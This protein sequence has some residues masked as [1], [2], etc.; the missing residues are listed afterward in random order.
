LWLKVHAPERSETDAAAEQAFATGHDVGAIARTLHTDGVMVPM[1]RGLSA[2]VRAT[3]KLIAES[4]PGPIFEATF[5]HDGVLVQVDVLSRKGRKG[6]HVAEVKSSTSMDGKDHY[7]ADL[8]TQIWVLREAG[9]KLAGA[10]IRHIDNRFVLETEGDYTLL[11]KDAELL[12]EVESL[13]SGRAAIVKQARKMLRGLEPEIAPGPQCNKP[14]ACEFAEWCQRN[15]PAA[16]EWPVTILPHGGGKKWEQQGIVDLL[17]LDEDALSE[18]HARILTATRKNVPYH[19]KAGAHGAMAEWGWPRAWLD[20]ETINFAIPRWIG[21][22]PY[23]QVPF[24]FSLHLQSRNG[25]IAH[26]EFL[27]ISGDD[28]RLACAKALVEAIPEEATIIAYNAS[29]EIRVLNDL[30]D[31]LPRYAKAL[32]SMARRTVDL[33]PIARKHWYHR[34]QR[35]SWSIKA[36]LPTMGGNGYDTLEVKDGGNAQ[37]A[38]LEAIDPATGPERK[39]ALAEALKA[40]RKRD[41]EAMI[42]V[43]RGLAGK[44]QI[45]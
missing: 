8:A 5:E 20:F 41:T 19:D 33:L 42:A 28:P 25:R 39:L 21:T 14:Y 6:W 26:R 30:A 27:D 34:D 17:A 15:L 45:A 32:R 16:P 43:A 29:F 24:Q 23:Q 31:A 40:Y 35:G 37:I 22:R 2:A 44:G 3:A 13:V 36:V 10:A 18:K 12:K 7:H 11:F 9:L 1:D 38:W 4:H